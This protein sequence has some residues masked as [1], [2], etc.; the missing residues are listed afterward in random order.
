MTQEVTFFSLGLL[1]LIVDH[2][3]ELG[4]FF[5]HKHPVRPCSKKSVKRA[6][7]NFET[8]E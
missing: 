3:L 1:V 2:N 7:K 4:N 6:W 8:G 5:E